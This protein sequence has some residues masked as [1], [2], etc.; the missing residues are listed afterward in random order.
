MVRMQ[1]TF[2]GTVQGVGF[3]YRCLMA[4]RKLGITGWVENE[5]DGSVTLEVQGEPFVLR[6]MLNEVSKTRFGWIDTVEKKELPII[7]EERNFDVR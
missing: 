4:A 5:W 3:R 6:Q 2:R 1:Y 7:R